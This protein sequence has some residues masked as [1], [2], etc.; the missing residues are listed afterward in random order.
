MKASYTGVQVVFMSGHTHTTSHQAT[1][2]ILPKG[3][4][5]QTNKSS[6][7]NSSTVIVNT[8]AQF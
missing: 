2:N 8:A 4:V 5:A 3:V 7:L 6:Y 1:L